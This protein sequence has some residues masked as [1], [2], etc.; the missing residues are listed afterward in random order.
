MESDDPR[1]SPQR[2]RRSRA[3][4][5]ALERGPSER[6][7]LGV[8]RRSH[9][10]IDF[11]ASRRQVLR[12]RGDAGIAMST[13]AALHR[14]VPLLP[15]LALAIEARGDSL[16]GLRSSVAR[17]GDVNGDG[18]PDFAVGAKRQSGWTPDDNSEP[19]VQ[20]RSGKDASILWVRRHV[21]LRS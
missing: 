11:S 5:R 4:P 14:L 6:E 7:T 1:R 10:A 12:Q 2:G 8:G 15:L 9:L 20:V 16:N 19:A 21:D 17:V 13:S 18:V 3:P